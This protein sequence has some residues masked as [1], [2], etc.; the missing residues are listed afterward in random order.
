MNAHETEGQKSH[1]EPAVGGVR[2]TLFNQKCPEGFVLVGLQVRTKSYGGFFYK[3][4]V[5]HAISGMCQ[6]LKNTR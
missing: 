4:D 3:G 1:K 5:V 6:Q 2:G